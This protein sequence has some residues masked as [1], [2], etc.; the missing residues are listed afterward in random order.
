VRLARKPNVILF[1]EP[2]SARDPTMIGEVQAVIRDLAKWG[3]TRITVT[4]EMK[5]VR[6]ICNRVYASTREKTRC[7]MSMHRYD[8]I[9]ERI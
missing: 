6:E 2:I 7:N 4:Y 3:T 5:F 8:E 9:G 1:E